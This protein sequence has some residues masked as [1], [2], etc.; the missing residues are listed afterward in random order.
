MEN[1]LIIKDHPTR[2]IETINDINA[3]PSK[4]KN[5][6][7]ELI[8][9][10]ETTSKE[11]LEREFEE[12][13]EWSNIGPTVEEFRTFCE[14][15]N[16]KPKYPTTYEEC[17]KKINACPIVSVSYDSDEDMSYNDE[18]DLTF[19]MLRKLIICRNAY[20]K[21]AGEEIGL[22]KSWEPVYVALEDNAYFTIQTFNSEIDKSG[23]SHRNA[24]LAFPTEGMRD[25]FYENFKDLIEQCKEWL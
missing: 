5:V 14:C 9:H 18:V 13:K 2:D 17:C 23:T 25:T 7:A 6:L 10:L 12:I 15:I 1:K 19:L 16:K 3:K 11:E 20:W 4:M 21:I 24:I 22:E 8:E